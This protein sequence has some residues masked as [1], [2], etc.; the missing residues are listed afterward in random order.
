MRIAKN[1]TGSFGV[2][3]LSYVKKVNILGKPGARVYNCLAENDHD[4]FAD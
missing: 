3:V 1:E 2:N 4:A